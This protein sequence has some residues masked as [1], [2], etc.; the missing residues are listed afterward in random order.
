[1][2]KAEKLLVTTA[3]LDSWGSN[4]EIV[5]LGEWCKRYELE[6]PLEARAHSL[7]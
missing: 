3:L 5:F 7:S 1:M 6:L 2:D 4:E